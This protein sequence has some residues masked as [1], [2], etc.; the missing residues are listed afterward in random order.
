[1]LPRRSTFG[2]GD[3]VTALNPDLKMVDRFAP[4]TWANDNAQDL[5]LG[6][7]G[8]DRRGAV[9]LRQPKVGRRVAVTPARALR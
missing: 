2:G 7:M 4:S 8:F 3:S 1:M 9:R 5:D 6:S